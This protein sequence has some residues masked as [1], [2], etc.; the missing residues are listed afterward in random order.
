MPKIL[1][2]DNGSPDVMCDFNAWLK[3][4]ASALKRIETHEWLVDVGKEL[5]RRLGAVEVSIEHELIINGTMYR[6]DVYGETINK[7]KIVF[8]AGTIN[9]P[10]KIRE[11]CK[12]VDLVLVLPYYSD[13]QIFTKQNAPEKYKPTIN[14]NPIPIYVPPYWHQIP[15]G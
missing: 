14:R 6:V 3:T 8:E 5:L 4:C 11:L 12:V 15:V 2:Y 7:E 13:L 9:K 10:S 1:F